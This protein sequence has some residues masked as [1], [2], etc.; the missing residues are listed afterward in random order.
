MKDKIAALAADFRQLKTELGAF[1]V[2]LT[3]GAKASLAAV[4][5]KLAELSGNGLVDLSGKNAQ[6]QAKAD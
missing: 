2:N 1:G 4:E 3:P 5:D 6:R